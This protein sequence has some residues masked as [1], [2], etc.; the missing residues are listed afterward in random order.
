MFQS[1]VCAML[2][3]CLQLLLLVW[4]WDL[5]IQLLDVLLT[6][7]LFQSSAH[8]GSSLYQVILSFCYV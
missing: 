8:V 7:T 1:D 4:A 6:N 5:Q 3:N 2:V